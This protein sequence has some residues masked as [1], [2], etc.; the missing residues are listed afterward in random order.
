M[1]RKRSRVL[2]AVFGTASLISACSPGSST[3]A[4]TEDQ[5]GITSGATTPI[6]STDADPAP[7][8]SELGHANAISSGEAR[9]RQ[10][11]V[12]GIRALER[13]EHHHDAYDDESELSEEDLEQMIAPA[14]AFRDGVAGPHDR[15]EIDVMA[16]FEPETMPISQL[17][18]FREAC[19]EHDLVSDEELYGEDEDDEDDWCAELAS[20]PLEEVRTFAEDEG[21]D[22]VREAFEACALPNPLDS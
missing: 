3:P 21:D 8:N 13:R 10:R 14:Q 9:L 18:R 17:E 19:F 15:P 4:L 1:L 22:V 16:V 11:C 6:S 7:A 2:I 20:F 5:T 12:V